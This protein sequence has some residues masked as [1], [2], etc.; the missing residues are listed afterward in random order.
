MWHIDKNGELVNLSKAYKIVIQPY[1]DGFYTE[2]VYLTKFETFAHILDYYNTKEMAEIWLK[3][4]RNQ[5]NR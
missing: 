5:I 1:C 2:A 3:N 4:L